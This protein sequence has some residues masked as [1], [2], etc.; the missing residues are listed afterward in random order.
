MGIVLWEIAV[1]VLKG[2]Y[3]APYFEEFTNI[4]NEIQILVQV[5]ENNLRPT[6]PSNCPVSVSNL[7]KSCWDSAPE[8]RPSA[9]QVLEQLV[10]I[11]KQLAPEV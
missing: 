11:K 4:V 8:N 2:Q 6:I 10:E 1:R 5:A 3:E 9:S 7:I